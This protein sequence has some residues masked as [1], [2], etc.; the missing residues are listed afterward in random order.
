MLRLEAECQSLRQQLAERSSE[1]GENVY[2]SNDADLLVFIET[3]TAKVDTYRAELS[4]L[5][6]ENKQLRAVSIDTR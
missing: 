2:V 6:D 4:Q 5:R 3:M 1:A